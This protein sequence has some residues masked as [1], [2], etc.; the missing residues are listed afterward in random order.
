MILFVKFDYCSGEYE[1]GSMVILQSKLKRVDAV[2]HR[3]FSQ[4]FGDKTNC[5]EKARLYSGWGFQ[6]AVKIKSWQEVPV[7]E[8]EILNRYVPLETIS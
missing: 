2:L 1:N 3:F 4:Y 6:V 5:E 7:A 8:L